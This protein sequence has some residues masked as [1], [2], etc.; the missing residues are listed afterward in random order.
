M[1]APTQ[2]AAR[3]RIVVGPALVLAAVVVVSLIAWLHRDRSAKAPY[4][5]AA[6]TGSIGLCDSSGKQITSGSTDSAPFVWRAVGTTPAPPG[7]AA[8]G[9]SATLYA[10]QPRSG[11]DP[12]GWSGEMLTAAGRYADPDHP[13]AAA[14][15][16]D[17]SLADFVAGFP[18][19]DDG[20]VQLRLY[21]SAPDQPPLITSYDALDIKV[22]GTS[23]RVVGGTSV[24]CSKAVSVSFETEIGDAR[25][26]ER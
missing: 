1:T 12:T 22:S 18:P 23:W 11:V 25:S 19:V 16:A 5:D 9:S 20:F 8:S 15:S 24:D 26:T 4:T 3:R 10:F 14:T 7:Y 17:V 21:L 6:V 13:T 2:V